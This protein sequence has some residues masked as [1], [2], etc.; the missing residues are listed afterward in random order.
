MIVVHSWLAKYCAVRTV[1]A[2]RPA[3]LRAPRPVHFTF[4]LKTS[5]YGVLISYLF[6]TVFCIVCKYIILLTYELVTKKYF[7]SSTRMYVPVGR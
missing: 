2:V 4:F 7:H 6:T 1:R 5:S 3:L